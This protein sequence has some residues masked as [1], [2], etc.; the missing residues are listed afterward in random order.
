VA[1]VFTLILS[2]LC[3]GEKL[4]CEYESSNWIY[5]NKTLEG[6]RISNQTIKDKAAIIE[7][8]F[9]GSYK[10]FN[11]KNDKNVEFIPTNIGEKFPNIVALQIFNCSIRKIG[12]K[13]FNN[14]HKLIQLTFTKNEIAEVDDKPFEDQTKL[15]WLGLAENKITRLYGTTFSKLRNLKLL[16]LEGNQ[17]V[18]IHYQLFKPLTSLNSLNL[19]KNNIKDLY[20]DVFNGLINV[21]YIY[22]SGNKIKSLETDLFQYKIK[23]IQVWLDSNKINE[24]WPSVFDY[25]NDLT[26]VNLTKNM[27]I[28][29]DF[30]KNNTNLMFV[31]SFQSMESLFEV[32]CKP[33]KLRMEAALNQS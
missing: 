3:V 20:D 26:Y 15:E 8:G 18:E 1:S 5:V 32:K 14:L 4:S 19:D 27:C 17:I 11:I 25:L 24:I 12:S 28:N 6:C 29:S 2:S 9:I 31:Y 23:L 10:A 13:H 30:A 33:H 21:Q 22:L 7:S 16:N